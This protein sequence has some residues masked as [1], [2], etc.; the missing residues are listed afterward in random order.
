MTKAG[1]V[2]FLSR[3]NETP[4]LHF[5][6][7]EKLSHFSKQTAHKY[8]FLFPMISCNDFII[9]TVNSNL[10][11]TQF[12]QVLSLRAIQKK[13]QKQKKPHELKTLKAQVH[14]E[15]LIYLYSLTDPVRS[16]SFGSL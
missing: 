5:K 13:N 1:A 4:S 15:K 7:C 8:Q 9:A 10:I 6:H 14:Y 12:R 3:K 11:N 16:R 2:P